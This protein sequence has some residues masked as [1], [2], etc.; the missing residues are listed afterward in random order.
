[1]SNLIRLRDFVV[2][3]TNLVDST[4]K[5]EEQLYQAKGLLTELVAQDDW[6]PEE[7]TRPQPEYYGQY[8]LHADPLG[9]F[10]LVSFVWGP[11]QSTPVH[12]HRVLGSRRR[13]ARCRN[14]D[15][16]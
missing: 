11:G 14:L 5:E 10:S 12:D 13:L 8:L 7:Y 9:R 6:L 2:A 3:V 1:M 15:L 4:S 16:L